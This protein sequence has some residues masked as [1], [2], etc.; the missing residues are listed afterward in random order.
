[1]GFCTSNPQEGVKYELW[2]LYFY[3]GRQL[4]IFHG[5]FI[6][7]PQNKFQISRLIFDTVLWTW[8]AHLSHLK[9]R[10]IPLM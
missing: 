7:S 1:V 6:G 10:A 2:Y 9:A 3:L 5:I 8:G 4:S